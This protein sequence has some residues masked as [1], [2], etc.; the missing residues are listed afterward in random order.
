MAGSLMPS[1]SPS[2]DMIRIGN[3]THYLTHLLAMAWKEAKPSRAGPYNASLP[4]DIMSILH[5]P[6]PHCNPPLIL[7]AI[8]ML[9]EHLQWSI[10]LLACLWNVYR[11]WNIQTKSK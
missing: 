2:N 3:T 11:N 7:F 6:S 10:Q 1:H 9:R 4:C 8:N 5:M